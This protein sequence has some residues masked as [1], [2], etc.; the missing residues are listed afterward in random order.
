MFRCVNNWSNFSNLEG[1][2]KGEPDFISEPKY[3]EIDT[4]HEFP[5]YSK[6]KCNSKTCGKYQTL[7]ESINLSQKH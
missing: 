6:C 1:Y 7:L 4:A 3:E 5:Q 2:C